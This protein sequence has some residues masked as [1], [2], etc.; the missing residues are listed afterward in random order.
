MVENGRVMSAL[1]V[2]LAKR[3][4]PQADAIIAVSEGVLR[5]TIEFLGVK[6]SKVHTVY[7]PAYPDNIDVLSDEAVEEAC[8]SDGLPVILA[9]GRL[10]KAKDHHSLVRAFYIL[11]QTFDAN[12]VIIG[13]GE[14]R[15]S[16]ESLVH[17]LDLT[18]NVHLLGFVANPFKYMKKASAYVL[19]SKYEGLPGSLIQALRCGCPVVSTNC[20]WGPAE[21]LEKGRYGILVPVGDPVLL[22]R[23]VMETLVRTTD[24][25]PLIVRG[26]E[27]STE[28]AVD[29]YLSLFSASSDT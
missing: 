16:L 25:Q 4:F 9:V 15:E 14:E 24:R 11:R 3:L 18:S 20:E 5:D 26:K 19:S 17:D 22:A 7:N 21:I 29:A 23:A 28:R 27:F 2:S 12:L 8:F 13:E 6:P 1:L 10:S